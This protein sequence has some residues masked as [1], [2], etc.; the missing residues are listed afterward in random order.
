MDAEHG[1]TEYQVMVWIHGGGFYSGS[2]HDLSVGLTGFFDPTYFMDR[3]EEV[4]IV[5][6]NYRLGLLGFFYDNDYD[7][8]LCCFETSYLIHLLMLTV[9]LTIVCI[10]SIFCDRVH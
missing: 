1:V 2:S 4:I 5:S 9:S 8:G 6:I 3:E 10:H 7:T